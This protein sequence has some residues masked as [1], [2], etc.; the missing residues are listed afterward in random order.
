MD[1]RI[2]GQI[3]VG[4]DCRMDRRAKGSLVTFHTLQKFLIINTQKEVHLPLST[5]VLAGLILPD[6]SMKDMYIK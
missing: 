5:E 3:D 2:N 4:L 6:Y 1:G